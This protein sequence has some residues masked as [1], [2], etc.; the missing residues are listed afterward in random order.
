MS[1]RPPPSSSYNS[2]G[3]HLKYPTQKCPTSLSP[4]PNMPTVCIQVKNFSIMLGAHTDY[5][6]KMH[7][8]WGVLF[9]GGARP[10][11][12]QK[13]KLSPPPG[14]P[15]NPGVIHSYVVFCYKIT[16][17]PLFRRFKVVSG[18]VLLKTK[19]G[20][21]KMSKIGI[22]DLWDQLL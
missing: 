1:T 8:R 5:S 3:G 22:F 4:P 16:I 10:V 11:K 6:Q 7:F 20:L 19:I 17:V 14:T 2:V 21:P 18:G 13:L 9:F 12:G 15:C